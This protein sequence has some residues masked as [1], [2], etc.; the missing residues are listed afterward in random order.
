MKIELGPTLTTALAKGR[1]YL[2]KLK[3]QRFWVQLVAL[4]VLALFTL[5]IVGR[6]AYSRATA[7]NQE[8][9]R[10]VQA[11]ESLDRWAGTMT[12]P[13]QEESTLWRESETFFTRL[14]TS[15][16]QPLSL[17]N[18]LAT[19]GEEISG[20]NVRTRLV[21]PDTAFV[22]PEQRVGPWVVRSGGA[23]LVVEMSGD[24]VSAISFLGALPPQVE[25][26]GMNLTSSGP[27]ARISLLLLSRQIT[28]EQ[29]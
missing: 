16:I 25:L 12:W 8:A 11:Q 15:S 3:G 9:L 24:W 2:E 27:E 19:R 29:L 26:S 28:Q 20:G 23:A 5:A 18:L 6:S 17:Y 10:L 4:T 1:L 14:G 21:S 22:P 13:T 7:L